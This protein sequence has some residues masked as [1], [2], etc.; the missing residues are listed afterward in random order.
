[1]VG[2]GVEDGV[3]AECERNAERFGRHVANLARPRRSPPRP[4]IND[5]TRLKG[6]SHFS[7]P[8]VTKFAGTGYK[9][10]LRGNK[11]AAIAC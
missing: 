11:T 2:V 10:N 1:M 3:G 7:N 5:N 8:L 4:S 9:K 6:P